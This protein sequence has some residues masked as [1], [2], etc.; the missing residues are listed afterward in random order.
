MTRITRFLG[1]GL[2]AAGALAA[3]GCGVGRALGDNKNAPD[4]FAIATKAPLVVPPDYA[5]R[6]PKPGESRPQELSPSERAREVLLGDPNAAP[7]SEGEQFLLRKAG[8]LN[9]DSNIRNILNAEVGGR[10]EKNRSLANQLIFWDFINGE[11]DDSA[12]PLRVDNPEE[13]M[14]ERQKRIEAVIGEDQ[15][16]EIKKSKALNLPG[17]F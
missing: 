13:W 1:I 17:I 12:A 3:S 7:P 4:E 14:A 10:G 6:P 2:L 8:A 9:A 11:V 16:V 5:L 15:Q